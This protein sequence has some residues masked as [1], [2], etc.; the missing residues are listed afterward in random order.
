MF[1]KCVDCEAMLVDS[2]LN[3]W[4]CPVCGS[5]NLS[6]VNGCG[7]AENLRP[8]E[9]MSVSRDFPGPKAPKENSKLL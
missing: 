6:I 1:Y 4:H 9:A 3:I 7:A 2:E 8:V 5:E